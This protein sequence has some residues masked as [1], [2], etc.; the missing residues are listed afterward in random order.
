MLMTP[1]V[2]LHRHDMSTV[3]SHCLITSMMC[4]LYAD[5]LTP[6]SDL[7]TI[8]PFNSF[9]LHYTAHR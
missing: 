4:A 1:T 8:S 5:L 6:R 2:H 3:L 9:V 7:H